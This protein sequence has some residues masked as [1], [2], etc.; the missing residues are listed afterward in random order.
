M[1]LEKYI[2]DSYLQCHGSVFILQLTEALAQFADIIMRN[3]Q[4]VR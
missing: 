2:S 4:L 1:R 3:L